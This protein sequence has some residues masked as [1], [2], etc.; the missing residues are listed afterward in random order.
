MGRSAAGVK[1]VRFKGDT[2]HVVDMAVADDE[3]ML[4][5]V[6]ENGYGQRTRIS[7]YPRKGR[8]GQGVV[9]MKGLDRNGEV[10]MVRVTHGGDD[11]ILISQSG[12]VVRTSVDEVRLVGRGAK[13]VR[14]M[15]L[16]EGDTVVSG[17]L[18]NEE[19]EEGEAKGSRR[20]P[21]ARRPVEPRNAGGLPA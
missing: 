7:E 5:T 10:V 15:S 12:K 1:G 13:G 9:N 19:E 16:N 2:D 14:V 4:L 6:S 11:L 8:G 17:V 18:V 20:A 3:A 21:R